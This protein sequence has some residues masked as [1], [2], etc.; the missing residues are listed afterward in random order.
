VRDNGPGIPA[1]DLARLFERHARLS[2]RPTGG[3]SST[4]LGLALCKQIVELHGGRIG[5]S[6]REGCGA[7]FWFE[8]PLA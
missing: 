5:A 7:L 8:L 4:G 1:P 2:N 3:E 6:N